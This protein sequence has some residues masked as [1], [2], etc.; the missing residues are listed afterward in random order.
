MKRI[1]FILAAAMLL[2]QMSAFA[3]YDSLAISSG[4]NEDVIANGVGSASA[5]TTNDVDGV[6]YAYVSNGWQATSTST[7]CTTGLPSDGLVNSA[8]TTGLQFQ[9]ADYSSNNS[10]RLTG[11]NNGTLNL[12]TPVA[13]QT[14]YIL[15]VSGSGSSTMTVTI[16]FSDGTTQSQSSMTVADWYGGANIAYN[17]F[18]R[19]NL[20]SNLLDG[21]S[22][23]PNLY[24]YSI[25]ISSA[26]QA[27]NISSVEFERTGGSSTTSVLNIFAL[28][29]EESTVTCPQPSTLTA[30][31]ITTNSADLGWTEVG[32]ATQWMISYGPS[33]ITAANGT[34]VLT[35]NN[36]KSISGLTQAMNY[37]F[38]VRAICSAGDSSLWSG[39]LN[40][41]T[42]CG[43]PPNITTVTNVSRCGSGTVVLQAHAS[44]GVI[45]WYAAATGGTAIDT[46]TQFT[47][48]NLTHTDTF[49]VAA[50]DDYLA[51]CETSIRQAVVATVNS[52]PVVSLGNDTT[53]CPG[54]TV[55]LSAG[56]PGANFSWNTGATTQ[57][58]QAVTSGTYVVNVTDVHG[59]VGKDT[60]ILSAGIQPTGNLSDSSNLCFGDTLTLDAG[61]SG[62]SYFW[63]TGES[64]QTIQTIFGGNYSVTVTSTDGCVEKDT[65]IVIS[66]FLPIVNL[67]I[68]T[69]I[70]N[71]TSI[72]LDAQ[73]SGSAYAW[74]TGEAT[75]TVQTTDSGS[76]SVTVT[77]IYGCY[78][79]DTMHL[80]FLTEPHSDGF[81]FVPL[82]Y[83][84][85]GKVAFSIINPMDVQSCTWDFGDG[86]PISTDFN[87]THTF[88]VNGGSFVVTLTVNNICG[89]YSA[90]LTIEINTQ[91]GIVTVV[92]PDN[93]L[94]VYPNPA[95]DYLRVEV[96]PMN[97]IQNVLIYDFAGRMI[98]KVCNNNSNKSELRIETNSLNPGIYLLRVQ[99]DKGW[100]SRKFE[101][102]R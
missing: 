40:F 79:S 28:S 53:I 48:P 37:Q 44:S 99:T 69:A 66:R 8:V 24:Q 7:A 49:W 83:D 65:T 59:C 27:K 10:L 70:C 11:S 15:A 34:Q 51:I 19:V 96:K 56:N 32:S 97:T 76:Y 18:Q 4:Y 17:G 1:I 72:T 82:F 55:T 31:N 36:P 54:A 20:T 80:S 29:I 67:G 91:T 25:T 26:N 12:Q 89:S 84:S 88:P 100:E 38:Y 62:S 77:D 30:A 22:T 41:A 58:I 87:P 61:N 5:T 75:Q 13:A 16:N 6:N 81:N 64:T 35:T 60:I 50:A 46:G 63:N 101:L 85:L 43:T 39:P 92:D 68:D 90:S 102:I 14:L 33:G 93:E 98:R 52:L 57:L 3:S 78:A 9:L 95:K 73:N 23:G 2:Y 21:S 42:S 74:N 94:K 47:T 71:N 86:S 45:R